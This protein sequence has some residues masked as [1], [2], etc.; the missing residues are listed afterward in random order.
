MTGVL[1]AIVAGARRSAL[2]REARGAADVERVASM[3]APD[4]RGFVESLS[5]P[6]TRIIAE[7]KRRSPSKGILRH[8]YDPAAIARGY[9]RAGAAAISVLTEPSFFDGSLDHLCAVRGAVRI[10]IL[11]K[12]FVVTEFQILEA[13]AAGADAVLLIAAALDDLALGA[14]MKAATAH[15]MAALVEVHAASEAAR[16]IDVGA[17]LVGVNS[18][19]LRTLEMKPAVFDEV[20]ARLPANVVAVAESGLSRPEQVR[21]LRGL[22][23]RAFLMGERFMTT[24]EAGAALAA[25]LTDMEDAS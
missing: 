20:A 12:D 10:P 1:D 7:C 5:R 9:E 25:F 2:D 19:D 15:G 16:V 6:G 21:R 8:D 23:Y 3:A 22:G 18:R 24:P 17:A 11:R 13:R 14:L 4:G